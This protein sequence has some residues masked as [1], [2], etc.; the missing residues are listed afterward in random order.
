MRRH[1]PW[2]LGAVAALLYFSFFEI[3]GFTDPEHYST[4]SMTTALAVKNW[5]FFAAVLG[6]TFIG[7]LVHILWPWKANPLGEGGG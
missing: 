7:F 6:G 5:P 2:I 4:L 3:K 1:L